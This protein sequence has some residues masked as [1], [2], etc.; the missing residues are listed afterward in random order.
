MATSR[1]SPTQPSSSSSSNV[2][3]LL[4]TLLPRIDTTPSNVYNNQSFGP[5]SSTSTTSNGSTSTAATTMATSTDTNAGQLSRLDSNQSLSSSSSSSAPKTASF[6]ASSSLMTPPPPVSKPLSSTSSPFGHGHARSASGSSQFSATRGRAPALH[7]EADTPAEADSSILS[8]ASYRSRSRSGSNRHSQHFSPNYNYNYN[9]PLSPEFGSAGGLKSASSVRSRRNW[10]EF[11]GKPITPLPSPGPQ[12]QMEASDSMFSQQQIVNE[13]QLSSPPLSPPPPPPSASYQTTPAAKSTAPTSKTKNFFG[14]T[15]TA[16]PPQPPR[17]RPT[18][19]SSTSSA[20]TAGTNFSSHN[21]TSSSQSDASSLASYP[22]HQQQQQPSLHQQQSLAYS[23]SKS[24]SIPQSSS[25]ASSSTAVFPSWP[26]ISS[27]SSSRDASPYAH[28]VSLP[29]YQRPSRFP[30]LPSKTARDVPEA[31]NKTNVTLLY[32]PSSPSGQQQQHLAPEDVVSHSSYLG[33]GP[34]PQKDSTG[35]V[36]AS[37]HVHG[38]SENATGSSLAPILH[39]QQ[40]QKAEPNTQ[41]QQPQPQQ[42]Q[43]SQSQSQREA[44]RPAPQTSSSRAAPSEPQAASSSSSAPTSSLVAT[45]SAMRLEGL[46][47]G[48]YGMDS[49]FVQASDRV[50]RTAAAAEIPGTPLGSPG[51]NNNRRLLEEDPTVADESEDES[52]DRVGKYH[53]EKTLGVGAFSRVVL[54]S[55]IRAPPTD[56]SEHTTPGGSRSGTPPITVTAKEAQK[57]RS[58]PWSRAWRKSSS[59]AVVVDGNWSS[60]TA[61]TASGNTSD[62]SRSPVRG[63]KSR[64]MSGNTPITAVATTFGKGPEA[65]TQEQQQIVDPV[66]TGSPSSLS[67]SEGKLVALKMLAREPC[68]QNERM[69]VSWVREV[70]V[71]K[72]ITH[73]C[74]IK[75]FHSFSTPKHHVLVLEC[76]SGGELFDYLANHHSV[77]AK[78]EWLA[79]RLYSELANAVGWMH[80]INLVHRDIKLENIILTRALPTEDVDKTGTDT[81]TKWS[82]GTPFRPSTIGSIPLLKVT[83]FGLSRFIDPSKPMLETRCGSEEYAS[84]ELIIGKKYDG[85]KTDVW[86]MGVVLFAILTGML[87]F[88]EQTEYDKGS[89]DMTAQGG[90]GDTS[91]PTSSREGGDIS[92]ADGRL[93]KARLL[94]IAKGDLRYPQYTNDVSSDT[95]TTSKFRLLTPSSKQFIS[96]LLRRDPIKRINAWDSWDDNW[97][98]QGSIRDER[99]AFGER[100]EIA[101]DPKSDTGAKWL[102]CKAGIKSG[103]VSGVAKLD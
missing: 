38:P 44:V 102:S 71:L 51:L 59:N 54:A 98:K 48:Q 63:F 21:R 8:L 23:P 25:S 14:T 24:T 42:Q 85:R 5:I 77:I 79:R 62:P 90:E 64:L 10:D 86:S 94:R 32:P 33:L 15:Y 2:Q 73:P 92:H 96:R 82:D 83:D 43:Q 34:P 91:L 18:K 17:N 13:D 101:P 29:D 27:N 78:R 3:H 69:K 89:G 20:D 84:P 87:P 72:H 1:S 56:G 28:N 19:Q 47:G 40:E 103:E 80:S 11:E 65:S 39:I 12:Q 41:S 35:K 37:R 7:I 57:R 88:G 16:T 36:S 31:E 81:D 74:L 53:I 9:L 61:S 46:P 95:Y 30:T 93:R 100:V 4:P 97:M 68:A 45:P 67:S 58:L 26:S 50:N 60:N 99:L 76:I 49:Q 6:F 66:R 22:H 75:V 52:T 55:P 70:E